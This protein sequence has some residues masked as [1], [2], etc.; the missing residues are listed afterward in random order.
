LVLIPHSLPEIIH[1]NLNRV[2]LWVQNE[3]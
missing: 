3:S 1:N 2:V